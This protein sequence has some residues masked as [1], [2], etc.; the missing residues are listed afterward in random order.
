MGEKTDRNSRVGTV[1]GI[2]LVL[3]CVLPVLYFGGWANG[4]VCFDFL[5]GGHVPLRARQ[6]FLDGVFEAAVAEDYKWLA[7]VS[8]YDALEE[9]KTVQPRI[10]TDYESDLI[11]SIC[12]TYEYRIRFSN[13]ATVHVGLYGI[14]PDCPDYTVTE[15]EVFQNITLTS[16]RLE[17]GQIMKKENTQRKIFVAGLVAFGGFVVWL[18]FRRRG[19]TPSPPPPTEEPTEE[20]AEGPT[21]EPQIR[22]RTPLPRRGDDG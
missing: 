15:E 14:W 10:T 18:V 9:L 11:D 2:V 19:N 1:V 8:E 12:G 20:V 5:V 21:G 13:G 3:A 22:P 16:I 7:T 4:Q 6:K 17:S